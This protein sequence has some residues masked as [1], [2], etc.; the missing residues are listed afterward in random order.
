M[1]DD[2]YYDRTGDAGDE[3]PSID[4]GATPAPVPVFPT[5]A[6]TPLS[7]NCGLFS[8]D[9]PGPFWYLGEEDDPSVIG[10]ATSVG[11]YQSSN[12]CEGF[13]TKSGGPTC[14]H[15]GFCLCRDAAVYGDECVP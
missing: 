5:T 10:C 13:L 14:C 12:G 8:E 3:G 4:V 9:N 1:C 2:D 11:D 15:R 7:E 6:P